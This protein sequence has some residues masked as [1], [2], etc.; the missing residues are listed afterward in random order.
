MPWKLKPKWKC[1]L[2]EV[3][4]CFYFLSLSLSLSLS[5]WARGL[6]KTWFLMLKAQRKL[7]LWA[8]GTFFW[9]LCD[10]MRF[11][12]FFFTWKFWFCC[13]GDMTGEEK[14]PFPRVIRCHRLWWLSFRLLFLVLFSLDSLVWGYALGSNIL[15][16]IF[17]FS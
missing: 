6:K 10:L 4:S 16:F 3:F 2:E 15:S 12:P 7:L 17:Y 11:F 14:T 5:N 1:R 8:Q 13:L 9:C